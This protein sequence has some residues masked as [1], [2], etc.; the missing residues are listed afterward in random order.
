LDD[1]FNTPDVLALI[2]DWV[3]AG[4]LDLAEPV[5]AIFG[6]SA[7]TEPPT[8]PDDV[9]ALADRREQARRAKQWD[10]ADRLRSAIEKAGWEI[11]DGPNGY[12]LV[13]K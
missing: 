6:L 9:L 1:D 11:D 13:P 3:G 5:L 4:R 10:E 12:V 2:H 8:A 7:V